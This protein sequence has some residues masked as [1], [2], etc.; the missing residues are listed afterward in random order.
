MNRNQAKR[1]GELMIAEARRAHRSIKSP[2]HPRPY[3]VSYLVRDE[4]SWDI[5][6]RYGSLSHDDYRRRRPCY[7]DVR[8][9]SY[10]YDQMQ[11]GGLED[12]NRD[13]E[14]YAY[15]FLPFGNDKEGT[16]H[17]LWRLA[18]TR[19]RES[20]EAHSSRK[21]N[22]L[23]YL[24]R[25]RQYLS[26]EKRTKTSDVQYSTFPAVDT[27]YW[28]S[29][30]EKSSALVRKFPSIKNSSVRFGVT[31]QT[32]VFASTE[33]SVQIQNKS[34]WSLE[35]YLWLLAKSGDAFPWTINYFVTDPAELPDARTFHKEIRD[36]IALLEKLSTAKPMRAYAGP[37]LL[38]PMP[39]GLL[40]HEA[41][42]H[43]LE[44]NRMLSAGEG[45]TFRD[46]MNEPVIPD[47]LTIVDE[48][49]A[50]EFDGQ[51]LVG[52]YAF[53][54][55]GTPAKDVTL[56]KNGVLKSF[57]TS[58]APIGKKHKSNGHSRNESYE[59]PISRMAVTRVIPEDGLTDDE[60][61]AALIEE[62]KQQGLPYGIRIMRASGGETTTEAYD[63][64]A[65]LG[66][67]NLAAKV[68]PD[69]RE[70]WIRGVDFV[71]T[72][73]N[74]TRGIVAA[75]ERVEVDNAYCGAESGWVPVSTISPAL[76]VAHL[77]LQA[78]SDQPFTQFA[79]PMPW[80]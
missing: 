72:P 54:D 77:E 41:L 43:R 38:D 80:E 4:E 47:F 75:G 2:G 19:Y 73:L 46:S 21:A 44:G 67:I 9:G 34:F 35:C 50:S 28:R 11:D 40:I 76:L 66:E 29:F 48:P 71:G 12:S 17:A 61:K 49:C 31:R 59:R 79:Y 39:A 37:V 16:Q 32:K 1:L 7:C 42:G 56:I 51:S 55:E 63:F 27:D 23:T 10:K 62:I 33:G 25:N 74:A 70:E 52:H 20:A 36:T 14:S 60:L 15:C 5:K 58:R 26:Y 8:V 78:K 22:E 64:Q 6:A 69:G 53:D 45:Q 30:V 13:D 65:F 68:Y 57:L 24:D 18:E 3:Y